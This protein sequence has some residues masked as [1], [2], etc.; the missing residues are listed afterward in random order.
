MNRIR[1]MECPFRDTVA[2][3]CSIVMNNASMFGVL[4]R[5][6]V[7]YRV[8]DDG[9]GLYPNR[10]VRPEGL[11][12]VAFTDAVFYLRY[13]LLTR[14]NDNMV[15]V[16]MVAIPNDGVRRV[17]DTGPFAFP[18]AVVS[19]AF[20]GVKPRVRQ[21]TQNDRMLGYL[22][23]ADEGGVVLAECRSDMQSQHNGR[24]TTISGSVRV[25]IRVRIFRPDSIRIL[26]T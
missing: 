8:I 2:Y 12:G 20:T 11:N 19:T 1:Q 17:L 18:F 25:I 14:T 9:I 15:E 3:I 24:V 4:K 26:T 7:R 6:D 16:L 23:L 22:V 13:R 21:V 10:V 5:I